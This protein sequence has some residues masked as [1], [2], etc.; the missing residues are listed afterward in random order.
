MSKG[1][2][3]AIG[4]LVV[5]VIWLVGVNLLYNQADSTDNKT[6]VADADANTKIMISLEKF[7]GFH[8]DAEILL[9]ELTVLKADI[10]AAVA[11]KDSKLLGVAINNTYR[12]MDNININRQPTIAP[13]E[14]CD[15]A[16]DT[17]SR[18]A[19]STKSYYSNAKKTTIATVNQQQKVFDTNFAACKSIVTDKSVETLYQDYQ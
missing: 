11:A 7:K 3:A 13:F 9:K 4:L 14:V 8:H 1:L 2:W 19:I 6:T 10:A 17:L 5:A 16:L 15:E 18:Y 12:V